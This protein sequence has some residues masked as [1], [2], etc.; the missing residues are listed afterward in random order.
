MDHLT[1]LWARLRLTPQRQAAVDAGAVLTVGLL[2][3]AF[4]FGGMMT[5]VGWVSV[6]QWWHAVLLLAGCAL[7]LVKFRAP[8]VVLLAGAVVF[9]ADLLIGGSI[10]VMLVLI[11]LI[12]TLA[13]V[14]SAT[15][16]R[17]LISM[18]AVTVGLLT[19]L[20]WLLLQ[21]P[22]GA[23][24]LGLQSFA[25]LGTPLW[26]G[27]SVRQQR[28]LA[29]LAQVR[30]EDHIHLAQL[31][32]E[33][34][35]R[36][37]REQMARDLH[38]AVAGH[39]SAIAL[40][41]EAALVADPAPAERET[42]SSVRSFSLE[43]L[44]EMRTMI[45]LLRGTEPQRAPSR[46]SDRAARERLVGEHGATISCPDL[47]A[48]STSVDQAGYRILQEALTN[49]TKHGQGPAAVTVTPEEGSIRIEVSNAV[50]PVVPIS[51]GGAH[52]PRPTYLGSGL[53]L[54]IMTERAR[55]AG[56]E[57]SAGL[58]GGRWQVLA[59]LPVPAPARGQEGR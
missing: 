41:T 56:G 18:V 46:L 17:R 23:V 48:L 39:L 54:A 21:G 14:G 30:A 12:Y 16:L 10:G 19:I 24:F 44:T 52:Q 22:R 43:A 3:L 5:D 26:W 20:G 47:P 28:E 42:L 4:G 31:R 38:D 8:G 7:M 32:H 15:A 50:E 36:D 2:V 33:E 25:V 59:R 35:A 40:R 9:A 29:E 1:A 45:E 13:L 27:R 11:D 55:A 51:D 53:G 49:A 34:T 57:L 37:E 6:P 58:R